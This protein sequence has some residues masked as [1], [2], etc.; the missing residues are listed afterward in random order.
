TTLPIPVVQ[1]LAE[2]LPFRDAT[3]EFLSMGYALRHVTDL[4]L[5]FAEYH[6]VLRPG[7]RLLILDFVRPRARAAYHLARLYLGRVIPWVV[8]RDSKS[9]EVRRL[10]R[11]CWDTV[12]H[13]VPPETVAA[14]LAD[15]GFRLARRVVW[16]GMLSEYVAVKPL[17]E[18]QPLA[19]REVGAQT[20][21]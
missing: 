18:A 11:Y 8:G 17:E 2:W 5:A 16:F 14:A 10:A 21:R 4:R 12:D 7:G 20:R 15:C 1:G 6:R 13:S 9:P 19:A 3:F